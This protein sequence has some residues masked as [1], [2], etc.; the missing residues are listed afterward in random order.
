MA[1]LQYIRNTERR[2]HTFVANRVATIHE[3]SDSEQ[4]CHVPSTQNPADDASR[5]LQG[6][7]LHENCRWLQGPQFLRLDETR[8][9]TLVQN[10]PELTD[11]DPEVK[12]PCISLTAQV[13]QEAYAVEK[14]WTRYSLWHQLLK[15]HKNPI[16]LPRDYVVMKLIVKEV[17][18]TKA[19]H[20][21][22]EHTLAALR[23]TFWI[24]KGRKI[25]DRVLKRYV[26]RRRCKW[27]PTEQQADLLPDRLRPEGKGHS[28]VQE[29]TVL[30]PIP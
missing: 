1:V 26:I 5:G 3:H 16:L 9:P 23:E 8:W 29:Q 20:S 21:G 4:W 24:P 18:S 15:D 13:G 6:E 12:K 11:G 19:G 17:H 30:D 7:E 27:K 2:F 14:L 25:I 28:S 22:R 10:I